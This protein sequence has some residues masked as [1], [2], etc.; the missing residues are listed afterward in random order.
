MTE[1]H[2]YVLRDI[3]NRRDLAHIASRRALSSIVKITSKKKC[4][5]LI[6]FKYGSVVGD[7]IQITDVEV[8]VIPKANEATAV[9]KQKIMKLID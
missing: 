9:I 2:L 6:T 5:D 7:A 3:P 4:P 1:S 8:F